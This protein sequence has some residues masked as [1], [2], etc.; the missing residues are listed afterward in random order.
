MTTIHTTTTTHTR[1]LKIQHVQK[2][3]NTKVRKYCTQLPVF[4]PT[5][6]VLTLSSQPLCE[7]ASV[8]RLS[9]AEIYILKK[10]IADGVNQLRFI[11]SH[12][13][14]TALARGLVLRYKEKW[15]YQFVLEHPVNVSRKA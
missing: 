12:N 9:F 14:V 7:P 1:H 10:K 15:N 6:I 3:N 13:I 8:Y 5:H 4:F 2:V 11:V